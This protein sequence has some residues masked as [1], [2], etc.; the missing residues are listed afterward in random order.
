MHDRPSQPGRRSLERLQVGEF[1]RFVEQPQE[2]ICVP[3]LIGQ[4]FDPEIA[5]ATSRVADEKP[6]QRIP[7][8]Q[9]EVRSTCG[10]RRPCPRCKY[11]SDVVRHQAAWVAGRHIQTKHDGY[12][13]EVRIHRGC[14]RVGT[15]DDRAGERPGHRPRRPIAAHQRRGSLC[16]I[17][18]HQHRVS[19]GVS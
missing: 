12:R 2:R 9:P 11:G 16:R 3:R 4:Q 7:C 5:A 10:R 17:F 1:C 8:E 14:D 13:E 18:T 15:A 19:L 6:L